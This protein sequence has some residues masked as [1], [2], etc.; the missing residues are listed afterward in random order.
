MA[1]RIKSVRQK[2]GEDQYGTPISLGADGKNIDMAS[3]L[4]LERQLMIGG[5]VK[6]SI[7]EAGNHTYITTTYFNRNLTIREVKIEDIYQDNEGNT[8]IDSQISNG[9]HKQTSV[10]SDGSVI[11][12]N[13]I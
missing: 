12:E 1:Q 5:N 8:I 13:W 11:Q 7:E 4:D 2:V 6:Y 3:G 10:S 9:Y